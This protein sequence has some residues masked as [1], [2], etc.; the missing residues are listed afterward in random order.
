MFQN[1]SSSPPP[2][3]SPPLDYSESE[4]YENMD[5]ATVFA[6]GNLLRPPELVVNGDKAYTRFCLVGTDY[7]GHG[8]TAR[9]T[10]VSIWFRAEGKI[11]EEIVRYGR[12]G[13]QLIV[14]A[15]IRSSPTIDEQ[16]HAYIVKGFRFGA[17]GKTKREEREDCREQGRQF[18]GLLAKALKEY[19][20][21]KDLTIEELSLKCSVP[22]DKLS[23]IED[24]S[25][26]PLLAEVFM[27][28][29]ATDGDLIA[30]VEE[31]SQ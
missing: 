1:V 30:L 20:A 12:K 14:H 2:S 10:V 13:D 24:L 27:I 19:R 21:K 22:P 29:V 8:N 28:A 4:D 23:G 3:V 7:T 17:P 18:R 15:C 25:Y 11:G 9:E 6:V 16:S 5:S 31:S 26:H